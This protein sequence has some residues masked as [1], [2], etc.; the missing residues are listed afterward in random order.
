M[1]RITVDDR[2]HA[3]ILAGLR[4]LQ[5]YIEGTQP[6]HDGIQEILTDGGNSSLNLDE[7]DQLCERINTS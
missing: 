1:M 7:I 3:A 2:E 6:I 5:H 4:L